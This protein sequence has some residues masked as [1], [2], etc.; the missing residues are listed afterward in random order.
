MISV[1]DFR[2]TPQRMKTVLVLVATYLPGYK[3]GGPIWSIANLIENLGDQ[4]NFRVVTSDRDHGESQSY[5]GVQPGTWLPLGR[6]KVMYLSKVGR[7]L[8]NLLALLSRTDCDAVYI[9]SVFDVRFSILPLLLR[10]INLWKKQVPVIVAPRGEL[11]LGAL[12]LKR[13]KKRLFLTLAKLLG[14]YRGVLWQA[15]SPHEERDIQNA[16]GNVSVALA[17]SLGSEMRRSDRAQKAT[18]HVKLV[19]LSRISRMKNLSFALSVLASIQGQVDLMIYGPIE[20][21]AYWSEC[22]AIMQTL[23]NN[24]SVKYC[25]SVDHDKVSDIFA[26]HHFLLL[27]TLGE[28]FGHVIGE[29]L[30]C[31]CPPI[32]SDRTPWTLLTAFGAGW[33]LSLTALDRFEAAIQ[34]CVNMDSDQYDAMS[35][36]ARE[37]YASHSLI[38]TGRTQNLELFSRLFQ[39]ISSEGRDLP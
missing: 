9:N 29:A 30:A 8:S 3:A 22:R 35:A 6:A 20:D 26:E 23:P 34:A 14:L 39:T 24:V 5:K 13:S 21:K 16:M 25:G 4:F 18:G 7:K 11:S 19:F 27:P 12:S 17:P 33:D 15:T 38:G 37:Y 32:I 2:E 28:N 31:G 10:R 36:K 1:L